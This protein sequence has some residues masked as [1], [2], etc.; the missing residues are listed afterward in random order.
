MAREPEI[1][2]V[3]ARLRYVGKPDTAAT[4]RVRRYDRALR[5]RRAL[6]TLGTGWGLAIAAIF[7]PVL[8]FIL[9][10]A[11][12]LGTPLIALQR[13]GEASVLVGASGACPACGAAQDWKLH[14]SKLGEPVAHRCESCGRALTLETDPDPR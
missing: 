5:M 14:P 4:A 10:P 2:P 7:L 1:Q 8:H 11:L 9:V 12:A 6:Q 13:W 3:T